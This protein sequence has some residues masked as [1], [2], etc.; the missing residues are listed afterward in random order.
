MRERHDRPAAASERIRFSQDRTRDDAE[1]TRCR[2]TQLRESLTQN[3][4]GN[5]P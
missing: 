1:F 5:G 3:H 2:N 4:A